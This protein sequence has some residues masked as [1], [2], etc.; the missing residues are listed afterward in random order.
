MVEREKRFL[1]AQ[2][3]TCRSKRK[4]KKRRLAPLEMTVVGGLG[5]LQ[6]GAVELPFSFEISPI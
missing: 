5:R 3:D 2:A 6:T 1:S 4:E